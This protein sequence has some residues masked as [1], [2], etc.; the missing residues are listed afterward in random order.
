LAI[1]VLERDL[2]ADKSDPAKGRRGDADRFMFHQGGD[3]H[4]CVPVSYLLKLALVEAVGAQD[5]VPELI[6]SEGLK[7]SE[8]FSCD[9]TSPETNSFHLVVGSNGRGLGSAL[10]AETARRFLL[11]QLLIQYAGRRFGLLESGQK[12]LVYFAPHPPVRQ[13]QLND[14]ISESFYRELFM[15]PCLSGWDRGEEKHRYMH[16]CHQV[17]SRAQIGALAR[18]RDAGIITSNLVVLPTSSNISLANNGTHVSLGSRRLTRALGDADSR[19]TLA[20]EK[21]FADLVI[22]IVEH[23][24][25]LFVGT[26]TAAP[27]RLDFSDFHPEKVLSFLPYQLDYTHLHMI[28]RRWRKKADLIVRPF[29][30]PQFD[31][32]LQRLLGLRGD[33]VPD[34]RLI[35]Y[36]V[37]VMSTQQCPALDG[38]LGNQDRLKQELAELGAFDPAMPIYLLYRHREFVNRG[39]FG[40]E[41][42]HYSLFESLKQ[43]LAPAVELQSLI[44]AL[45]FKYIATGL[46][47]HRDIP[48][49][50]EIESERRQIF[51]GAAIGLPTFFVRSD[52]ANALLRRIIEHARQ[53]RPSRRYPGYL[54]VRQDEYRLA[55]LRV[56]KEDAAELI[57]AQGLGSVLKETAFRLENHPWNTVQGRL[58]RHVLETLNLKSP[59]QAEALDFNLAAEAFYREGLRRRHMLEAWEVLEKDLTGAVFTQTSGDTRFR[60]ALRH[61]LAGDEALKFARRMKE[62]VLGET[63]SEKD[64]TRLVNLVILTVCQASQQTFRILDRDSGEEMGGHAQASIY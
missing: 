6:R 20:H 17:L 33:Y 12:A 51:F 24:L 35:D 16:L 43:D 19:L 41:G 64:L 4:L 37:C 63:A 23:F 3:P 47:T 48:D 30:P 25:P 58:T 21:Y 55:L 61:T 1:K 13:K 54:R 18:L 39:F 36:L 14:C 60:E 26:Y 46:L 15:N 32:L 11:T 27:Y 45:A 28:W 49:G 22:K 34:F 53:V 57:E 59:L 50:P 42:R 44:T 40:F 5:Q 29:G 56:L 38:V 31:R 8:H 9:N 10:A 52:T 62:Q 2:L 7:Y